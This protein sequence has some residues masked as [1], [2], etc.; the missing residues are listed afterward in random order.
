MSV[1]R[2]HLA[3]SALISLFLFAVDERQVFDLELSVGEVG[4]SEIRLAP[5]AFNVPRSVTSSVVEELKLRIQARPSAYISNCQQNQRPHTVY[6]SPY[7]STNSLNSTDSSGVRSH[8]P[9]APSRKKRV[10]PRPPSQN[11]IPEDREHRQH[12]T[13]PDEVMLRQ[14]FHVSSPN[15]SNGAALS[16]AKPID[17]SVGGPETLPRNARPM[18]MQLEAKPVENGSRTHSRTSSDASDITRDGSL[19]DPQP[20]KRVLAGLS[21]SSRGSESRR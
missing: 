12:G 16:A 14:N 4:L 10:A 1:R 8:V 19:P 20:R 15:L 11:S 6:A 7:S 2:L 13:E 18:S 17:E 5:K 9:M 3:H 21:S